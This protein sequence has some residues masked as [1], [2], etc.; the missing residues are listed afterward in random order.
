MPAGM[1]ARAIIVLVIATIVAGGFCLLDADDG[2]LDLCL[3]FLAMTAGSLI[4][5]PLRLGRSFIPGPSEVYALSPLDLPVPPPK[6]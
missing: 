6:A 1:R 4:A 5:I 2:A 3:A